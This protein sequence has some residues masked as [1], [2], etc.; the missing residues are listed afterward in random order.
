[1]K[2]FNAL[3]KTARRRRCRVRERELWRY[4]PSREFLKII[5]HRAGAFSIL[6]FIREENRSDCLEVTKDVFPVVVINISYFTHYL[7]ASVQCTNMMY[8][9]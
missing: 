1:M 3:S 5:P 2:T 8:D 4:R 6:L 7:V 9:L